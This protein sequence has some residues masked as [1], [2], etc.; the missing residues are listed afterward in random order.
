MMQQL[1]IDGQ[2][3]DISENTSVSFSIVSNLLTGAASFV[4]NR[5]LTIKLPFTVRNMRLIEQAQIVQAGSGFPYLFHGVEYHRDGVPVI[6]GGL[7]RL[8]SVTKDEINIAVTWGVRT[9]VDALLTGDGTL[10]DITTQAAIEFHQSPQVTPY[11]DALRDDVFFA[12]LDTI[13]HEG[14][15]DH[16]HTHVVIGSDKYEYTEAF[17]ASSYLHPSVRMSWLLDLMEQQYGAHVNWGDDAWDDINTMIVPLVSKIP[18]GT[19]YSNGFTASS[20]EPSQFGGLGGN[21]IRFTTT[22]QS[23]IIAQQTNPPEPSLVCATSFTGLIRYQFVMYINEAD[24]VSVSYPVMR[25]RYGYSL[26]LRVGNDW[27]WCQI[28]PEGMT[29][30]AEKVVSG[31][32]T[33][34]ATGYLA[35]DMAVGDVIA[36]RIAPI[37]GGVRDPEIASDLHVQGGPIYVSDIVGKENE[38]QPGQVY[39]VEGNLPAIKPIDLIKFLAAVTGVFPVQASTADEL[40]MQPVEALFDWDNAVDWSS[41]VLSESDLPAAQENEYAVNGWAQQNWWRWK[42]DDTVTGDYDGSILVDDDTL[43]QSRDVMEFPFAATDGNNIPMYTTESGTGNNRTKFN[44]VEPRVLM[45]RRGENDEA[46]GYFDMDMKR[47]LA[48]RYGDLAETLSR[49]VVITETIRINDVELGSVD[50]SRAIFIA[51]HGA[52]FALLELNVKGDGTAEAKLLK[53]KKQEEM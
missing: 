11:T 28:L 8:T 52:Y 31:K 35:V 23:A 10:A 22:H 4:G 42:Q 37:S 16:Y 48:E 6:Q 36:M 50:E 24:L 15:N 34:Y 1:F 30:L 40:I 12:A 38:V 20:A 47:I 32:L 7:G 18:N 44:K 19:T 21:F 46:V 27:H 14:A 2:L 53:L 45:M 29:F 26:G 5:T 33:I 13:R 25:A 43:E 41:R 51:Q 39:P 17:S 9:A 3:A 49:P